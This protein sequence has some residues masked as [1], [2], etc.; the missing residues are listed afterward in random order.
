MFRGKI[1]CKYFSLISEISKPIITIYFFLRVDL[2]RKISYN[3]SCNK[4]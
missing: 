2:Q 3:Q 4:A 1:N